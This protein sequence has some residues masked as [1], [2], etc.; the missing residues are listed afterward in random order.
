[1]QLADAI[2]RDDLASV[3]THLARDPDLL[4]RTFDLADGYTALFSTVVS[5]HN[6]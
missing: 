2:W 1:M 6:F 3:E 5:R 4:T